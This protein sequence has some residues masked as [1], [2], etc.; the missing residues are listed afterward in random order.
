MNCKQL[1]K[2]VDITFKLLVGQTI[3]LVNGLVVGL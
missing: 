3:L 2:Y 1:L